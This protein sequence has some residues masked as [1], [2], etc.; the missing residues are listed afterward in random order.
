[1]AKNK[2][3]EVR[4]IMGAGFHEHLPYRNLRWIKAMGASERRESCRLE[5]LMYNYRAS[6]RFFGGRSRLNLGLT[7]PAASRLI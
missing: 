6:F 2:T 3:K 4:F 1:M 7:W 5:N